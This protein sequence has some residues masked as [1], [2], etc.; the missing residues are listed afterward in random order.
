MRCLMMICAL[1]IGIAG[2]G[3]TGVNE[4]SVKTTTTP[5]VETPAFKYTKTGDLSTPFRCSGMVYFNV[6]NAG[7]GNYRFDLINKDTQK[8]VVNIATG[9]GACDYRFSM[10]PGAVDY[11]FDVQSLS[12]WEIAVYGNC[13]QYVTP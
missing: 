7:P 5:T 11:L 13:Y 9:T 10:T 2:C 6:K 12:A 4:D 8:V 3:D 1:C